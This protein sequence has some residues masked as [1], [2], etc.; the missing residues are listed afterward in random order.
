MVQQISPVQ[1]AYCVHQSENKE[2]DTEIKN[3]R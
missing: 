2:A 3:Q 1:S